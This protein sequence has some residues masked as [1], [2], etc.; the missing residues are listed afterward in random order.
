MEQIDTFN[1]MIAA[2]LFA[3]LPTYWGFFI[4]MN[5][6]L[7]E[8]EIPNI[9]RI[10]IHRMLVSSLWLFILFE[11]LTLGLV[12]IIIFVPNL[13]SK[14]NLLYDAI[15]LLVLLIA[16]FVIQFKVLMGKNWLENYYN[17]TMKNRGENVIARQMFEKAYINL[18]DRLI[19][20]NV[21]SSELFDKMIDA[22]YEL[23]RKGTFDLSDVAII[24]D[25]N[26]TIVFLKDH[27]HCCKVENGIYGRV[28]QLS[29]KLFQ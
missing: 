12:F 8:C 16:L 24:E 25:A 27:Q 1:H 14:V 29:N 26:R 2:F 22:S 19:G 4:Y 28:L 17:A 11:V 13:S 6:I 5:G 20:D 18:V 21:S 3:L 9:I 7:K 10:P 23:Y 15:L